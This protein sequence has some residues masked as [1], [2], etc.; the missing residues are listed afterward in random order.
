MEINFRTE[1]NEHKY[2]K[3]KTKVVAVKLELNMQLEGNCI[4]TRSW[5]PTSNNIK[6]RKTGCI[7]NLNGYKSIEDL[8][9][10]INAL[11]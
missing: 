1:R 5:I 2:C 4:R 11:V 8:L 9:C 6:Q 3:K 10:D 7:N